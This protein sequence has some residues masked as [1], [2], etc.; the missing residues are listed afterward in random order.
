MYR[1][2]LLQISLNKSYTALFAGNKNKKTGL[3]IGN[4][5]LLFLKDWL[6]LLMLI[7]FAPCLQ[8][9]LNGLEFT[10]PFKPA[11]AERCTQKTT[12]A[13]LDG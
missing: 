10:T 4:Y 13:T 11:R 9:G 5:P 1:V 7:V 8:Q 3:I 12:A 2:Y 6:W